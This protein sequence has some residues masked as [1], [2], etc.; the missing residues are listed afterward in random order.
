MA[1]VLNRTS[2]FFMLSTKAVLLSNHSPISCAEDL[3]ELSANLNSNLSKFAMWIAINKN[4]AIHIANLDI[5]VKSEKGK[6]EYPPPN[7][8]TKSHQQLPS[9]PFPWG[10]IKIET[11]SRE[12]T[13][14][15]SVD[16]I[17]TQTTST[18][19]QNMVHQRF[20]PWGSR[21][22]Q[23]LDDRQNNPC[24]GRWTYRRWYHY[25]TYRA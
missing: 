3:A 9:G 17:C 11:P 2:A 8:H 12:G 15:L 25:P 24:L 1:E 4:I 21:R 6:K 16:S 14:T 22:W 23:W 7:N 10:Y 5:W 13:T 19:A 20:L 18:H